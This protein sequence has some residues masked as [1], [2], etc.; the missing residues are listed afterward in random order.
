MNHLFINCRCHRCSRSNQFPIELLGE[1]STCR[2][3]GTGVTVCDADRLQAAESD[4][5]GWWLRFTESGARMGP[6][7][8]L[9]EKSLPR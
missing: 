9:P 4:S 3:C 5:M 6:E 7:I 2:H 8:E 1:K